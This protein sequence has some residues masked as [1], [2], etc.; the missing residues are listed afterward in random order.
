MTQFVKNG[1]YDPGYAKHR[2]ED[3]FDEFYIPP[4]SPSTASSPDLTKTFQQRLRQL[5]LK[6]LS[7]GIYRRFREMFKKLSDYQKKKS[8]HDPRQS[9]EVNKWLYDYLSL[10][11]ALHKTGFRLIS[12]KTYRTSDIPDWD[13]FD[14]D[15]SNFGDHAIEP[16]LYI[17][18][19][20]S[21][22]HAKGYPEPADRSELTRILPTVGS[23]H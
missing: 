21:G 10:T 13:R 15:R 12:R 18:G 3:V 17:E 14:L 4:P 2:Y 23:S 11:I 19:R 1:Y 9:G 20:K 5:T 6:T 8:P 22:E 7:K 16:S